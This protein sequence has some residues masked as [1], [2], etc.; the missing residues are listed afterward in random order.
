M[1]KLY[2]QTENGQPVNHPALEEN[3]L[4]AFGVIPDNWIA[5]E[6]IERPQIGVYDLFDQ[7]Y[8]EYQ[9]D[10]GVYKD[11]WLIRPMNELEKTAKQQVVK[12]RWDSLPNRE[13]FTAWVFDEVTCSYIPPVPRPDDGKLYQWDGAVNNWIEVTPPAII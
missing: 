6:R 11:V 9:L 7:D 10:G 4:Q 3:L 2:I 12:D 5:F 1:M 13:N 8:P